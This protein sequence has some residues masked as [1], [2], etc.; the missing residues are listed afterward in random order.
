MDWNF[1]SKMFM[2]TSAGC[3]QW[4]INQQSRS[5]W[6]ISQVI[7]F[8]N[9][10]EFYHL[11]LRMRSECE[12]DL[13]Y[14]DDLSSEVII[15]WIFEPFFLLKECPFQRL[16]SS[17]RSVPLQSLSTTFTEWFI[18][19]PKQSYILVHTKKIFAWFFWWKKN[20]LRQKAS[21]EFW[22]VFMEDER[23]A[24][25]RP[26]VVICLFGECLVVSFEL[27][28]ERDALAGAAI[29]RP[30]SRCYFRDII[31]R[32]TINWKYDCVFTYGIKRS[33]TFH[34]SFTI[35]AL[36]PVVSRP[37]TTY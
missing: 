28:R 14:F 18:F 19:T 34:I 21:R 13:Y 10:T 31:K 23:F 33:M 1:V 27:F 35:S 37:K 7:I 20:Q 36:C 30:H 29:T 12:D 25:R 15:Q 16:M 22:G 26:L 9:S 4:W 2:N 17:S 24:W 8:I 5:L 3:Q 32:R 6:Y 11:Q